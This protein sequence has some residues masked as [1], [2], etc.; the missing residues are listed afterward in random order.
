M[1]YVFSQGLGSE[2]LRTNYGGEEELGPMVKRQNDFDRVKIVIALIVA[3]VWAVSF[4][5]SL[6][7]ALGYEPDPGIHGVMLI[8][9]GSLFGSTMLRRD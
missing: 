4:L 6:I 9:V 8:V 1:G 7:P 5:A 3:G 2:P